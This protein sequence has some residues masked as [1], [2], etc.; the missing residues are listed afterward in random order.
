MEEQEFDL[1]NLVHFNTD[2]ELL[3]KILA[4][5]LSRDKA[6]S[7]RFNNL[8]SLLQSFRDELAL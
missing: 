3:K 2:Y 8:E 1:N 6:I 5:L 7:G 4:Y